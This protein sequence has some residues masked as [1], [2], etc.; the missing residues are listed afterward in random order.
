[1]QDLRDQFDDFRR[2]NTLSLSFHTFYF[3]RSTNE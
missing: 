3:Q 1:M 2:F